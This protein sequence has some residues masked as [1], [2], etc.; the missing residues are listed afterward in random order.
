MMGS[1][2]INDGYE[3]GNRFLGKFVPECKQALSLQGDDGMIF[4]D[5]SSPHPPPDVEDCGKMRSS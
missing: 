5:I 2:Y 4:Q 1:F 3:A